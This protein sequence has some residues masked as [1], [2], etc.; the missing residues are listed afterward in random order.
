MND[1][2]KYNRVLSFFKEKMKGEDSITVSKEELK[3][4]FDE[5]KLEED[6]R[7]RQEIIS[8]FRGLRKYVDDERAEVHEAWIS[9]LER[10][11]EK[12]SQRVISAEAKEAMYGKFEG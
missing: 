5:L 12:K 3:V 6:E 2:E 9:W 10:Q 8:Y 1:K 4:L 11:G 7:I